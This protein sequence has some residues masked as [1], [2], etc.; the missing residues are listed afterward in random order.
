MLQESKEMPFE[1]AMKKLEG[2]V[3]KLE[4]GEIPLEEA[5]KQ[6]E[7]GVKLAE[8][9]TKKLTEA[10]RRVEVL[11]KTSGGKFK[12]EPYE[13]KSDKKKK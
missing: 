2:I 8:V 3:E 9:C 6:Y 5:L 1:T 12:A 13:E 11:M 7:E 4:S 10:E